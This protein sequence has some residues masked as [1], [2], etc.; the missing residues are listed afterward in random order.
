MQPSLFDSPAVKP[1]PFRGLTA[2]TR[3]ASQSGAVHATRARGEKVAAVLQVIRNHGAITAQ[4]ISGV[5]GYPINSVCSLLDAIRD[6]VEPDGCELVDWG[7]GRRPTKRT[8]WR[9]R[10]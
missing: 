5:T 8:R 1:V 6:Q 4:D 3:E 10:R 2:T 9:I 7:D